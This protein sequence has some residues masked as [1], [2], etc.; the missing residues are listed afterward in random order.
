M[1]SQNSWLPLIAVIGVACLGLGVYSVFYARSPQAEISQ[2]ASISLGGKRLIR[3]PAEV[4]WYD[5]GIDVSGKTVQIQYESGQWSNAPSSNF[6]DGMGKI[7]YADTAQLIVP[8]GNLSG[9][10]GKVG[11]RAFVV[12]NYYEGTPGKGELYL[13]LN[14]KSGYFSDNSGALYVNISLIDNGR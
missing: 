5:T 3:I 7:G 1:N 11:N 9:L 12:G 14:D 8:S 10:M 4:M 2:S 13:S 6:C